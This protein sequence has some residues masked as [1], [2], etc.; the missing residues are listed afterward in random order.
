MHTLVPLNF[1]FWTI[2]VYIALSAS[3]DMHL[4]LCPPFHDNNGMWI[5]NSLGYLTLEKYCYKCSFS[6]QAINFDYLW[7]PQNCSYHR[8]STDTIERASILLRNQ[9]C[10]KKSSL[11]EHCKSKPLQITFLGD[12]A[13]RG[14]FCS[15]A[16][17][18][19]GNETHGPCQNL[20]C[21][22]SMSQRE[23]TIPFIHRP[24]TIAMGPNL[25]LTFYYVK[26]L[27]WKRLDELLEYVISVQRPNAIVFSTGAWDFYN[28]CKK[29]RNDPSFIPPVNGSCH[30]DDMRQISRSRSD[31]WTNQTMHYLSNLANQSNVRLIYRNNH[32]NNR[33]GALCADEELE[34]LLKTSQ[35]EIWDNRIMSKSVWRNQSYDGFHFDW[36]VMTYTV[37][38][39]SKYN[40][41]HA[42]KFM[43]KPGMLAVQL[44]HSL[45]QNLFHSVL[46]FL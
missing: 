34:T 35:W 10:M 16:R 18:Y 26:S 30:N 4:P 2:L 20:V 37:E 12:S 36:P 7:L 5:S 15:I 19:I 39:H 1:L 8:F 31:N 40:A 27:K 11:V 25:N 13:L 29:H 21:G 6:N 22:V 42:A 23:I 32:Y 45:L 46:K 28:L 24:I 17:I 38:D 14:I 9:E 43:Q 3:F 44:A 41:V 33:Y